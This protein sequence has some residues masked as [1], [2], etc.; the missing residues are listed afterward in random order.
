MNFSSKAK[1]RI[2]LRAFTLIELLVVIAIITILAAILLPV[3]NLAKE[4]AI[5]IGAINNLRQNTIAWKMYSTDN[6]MI[7]PPN[8]YADYD[9]QGPNFGDLAASG[10]LPINTNGEIFPTWA[11]GQMRGPQNGAAPSINVAPY[12]G[13]WDCTNTALLLDAKFSVMGSYIQN[14]KV[15][16][17]P[18]DQSLWYKYSRVRSFSM[19]CAIGNTSQTFLT[20]AGN[21]G[22]LAHIYQGK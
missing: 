17:D 5:N 11:C 21:P 19:N 14:P 10:A 1:R 16:L 12:V 18:G 13:A 4:K 22:H 6:A 20:Q 7:L 3:L 2:G 8:R 9:S 15:Y